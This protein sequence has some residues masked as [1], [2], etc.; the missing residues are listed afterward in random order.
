MLFQEAKRQTVK[1]A[2]Q[3]IKPGLRGKDKF[4]IRSKRPSVPTSLPR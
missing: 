4:E 2:I 1:D 3:K